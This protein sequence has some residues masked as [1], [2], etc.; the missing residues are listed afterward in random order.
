MDRLTKNIISLCKQCVQNGG[1]SAVLPTVYISCRCLGAKVLAC[2]SSS[3]TVRHAG[4]LPKQFQLMSKHLNLRSDAIFALS[5]PS[6]GLRR[7]ENG[8]KSSP[9]LLEGKLFRK[10]AAPAPWSV[11]KLTSRPFET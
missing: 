5:D 4:P 7:K 11:L 2:A 10:S 3:A 9:R 1:G 8:S 6:L